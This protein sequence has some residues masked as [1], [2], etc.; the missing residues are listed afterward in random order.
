MIFNFSLLESEVTLGQGATASETNSSR[1]LQGAYEFVFNIGMVWNI[2]PLD[3]TVAIFANRFGERVTTAGTFGVDDEIEQS[4][5]SLDA[6][7]VKKL[8]ESSKVKLSF[9]NILDAPFVFEQG[10]FTTR[11]YSKGWSIGLSYSH[12]L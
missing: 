2:E 9:E 11:E 4:R 10:P 8:T 1:P 3:M 7:I 5:W 6:A 12:D